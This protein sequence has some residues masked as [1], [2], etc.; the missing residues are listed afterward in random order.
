MI[1]QPM[2]AAVISPL[3]D[4]FNIC[5]VFINRNYVPEAPPVWLIV[6]LLNKEFDN[7]RI[8][9][10]F[11]FGA[12]LAEVKEW[13]VVHHVYGLHQT[14][15]D[16]FVSWG[17]TVTKLFPFLEEFAVVSSV[18]ATVAL[19]ERIGSGDDDLYNLYTG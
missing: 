13:S 16:I 15:E 7:L 6:H 14:H 12:S 4:I 18:G 5:P 1:R 9:L 3:M 11:H 2:Q 10:F 8:T 17:L 19:G